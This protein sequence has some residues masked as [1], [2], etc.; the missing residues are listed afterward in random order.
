MSLEF[1]KNFEDVL[2]G[3]KEGCLEGLAE[4]MDVIHGLLTTVEGREKINKVLK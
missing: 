3:Q 2:K 4:S 1:T